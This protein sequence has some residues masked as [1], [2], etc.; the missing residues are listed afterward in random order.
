MISLS[1]TI[2]SV[3]PQIRQRLFSGEYKRTGGVI[4]NADSGNIAYLLVNR[5]DEEKVGS[6]ISISIP[7]IMDSTLRYLTAGQMRK[8]LEHVE[9]ELDTQNIQI[10]PEDLSLINDTI[11]LIHMKDISARQL[12]ETTGKMLDLYNRY[13]DIFLKY[14][15]DL[16][17]LKDLQS[18]PFI[19]ILLL[20]AVDTAKLCMQ[21]K[22]YVEAGEW[23][24]K[25]YGD[26]IEAMKAYCILNSR[27]DADHA[28]Y[29]KI[30][31][32]LPKEFIS[33]LKEV[34]T[35]PPDKPKY[36]F[37]PM[38]V[39]YLWNCLEYLEGYLLELEHMA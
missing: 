4:R 22:G 16:D 27:T 25:V 39:I 13:R 36:K 33:E 26:I 10:K 11:D 6:S 21:S 9:R 30:S 28:H 20:I 29:M 12:R 3:P 8:Q 19:K 23:I 34:I 2:F 5:L 31:R 24:R 35:S 14:L 38:E 37:P 18:F 15:K 17:R 7:E 1:K 32:Y